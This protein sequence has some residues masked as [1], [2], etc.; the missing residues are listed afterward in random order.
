[1]PCNSPLPETCYAT[2][3]IIS[4]RPLAHHLSP[5]K[6]ALHLFLVLLVTGSL[7]ACGNGEA[8]PS[9]DNS[10]EE[11]VATA[12]NPDLPFQGTLT[13]TEVDAALAAEGEEIFTL[14]CTTCHKMG[15]R[16]VG[17]ALDDV[18]DRRAPEW[19]MNMILAPDIMVASDPDAQALLGEFAVPMTNQNLT[20]EQARALVE[21]LRTTSVSVQ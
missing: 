1:M 14:Q 16:Y 21:Y 10:A 6:P 18:M 15:E 2:Q 12:T 11:P 5:M 17:P 13:L 9:D 3:F 7:A 8:T 20:E 19:V 4:R